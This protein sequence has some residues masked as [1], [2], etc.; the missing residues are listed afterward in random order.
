MQWKQD[1]LEDRGR[2][3]TDYVS[4]CGKWRLEQGHSVEPNEVWSLLSVEPGRKRYVSS[5]PTLS[6]A[7]SAAESL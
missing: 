4:D 7:K 6:D 2:I 1:L 3:W 5:H